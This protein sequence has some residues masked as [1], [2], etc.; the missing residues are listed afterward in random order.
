[1]HRATPRGTDAV[2]CDILFSMT[3]HCYP[4]ITLSIP[5]RYLTCDVAK[6][7]D[8]GS[9]AG[10]RPG[11]IR[12]LG[13]IA[14]PISRPVPTYELRAPRCGVWHLQLNAKC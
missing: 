13:S 3:R 4:A 6:A 8:V 5:R 12:L 14:Y 9:V 10:P 11:F 7:R 2:L 1:M